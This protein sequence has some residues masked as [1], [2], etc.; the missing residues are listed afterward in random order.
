MIALAFATIINPLW[1]APATWNI[2]IVWRTSRW[3][4]SLFH[5]PYWKD[6][7]HQLFSDVVESWR[8]FIRVSMLPMR[9][10]PPACLRLDTV[11][12]HTRDSRIVFME[13]D[14]RYLLD[15]II[16]FP[17]SVSG[18]KGIRWTP[19]THSLPIMPSHSDWD[20]ICAFLLPLWFPFHHISSQEPTYPKQ[21]LQRVCPFGFQVQ[22]AISFNVLWETRYCL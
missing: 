1:K 3:C 22:N 13:Q 17:I 10:G 11:N 8:P 6:L 4:S 15:G 5:N 9:R 20:D 19:A 16:Q 2:L 21:S 12:P 14:H 7:R 18:F